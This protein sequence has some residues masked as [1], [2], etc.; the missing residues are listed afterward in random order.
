MLLALPAGA[1][2]ADEI[3][4]NLR[5]PDGGSIVVEIVERDHPTYRLKIDGREIVAIMDG[6]GPSFR[7]SLSDSRGNS[8]GRISSDEETVSMT[9][10]RGNTVVG[11][12]G[13][14]D[15]ES[16][17]ELFDTIPLLF[18]DAD[19]LAIIRG[20]TFLPMPNLTWGQPTVL[21]LCCDEGSVS[22]CFPPSADGT[23]GSGQ[24]LV[25]CTHGNCEINGTWNCC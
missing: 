15:R 14:L 25:A 19:N 2:T 24:E 11:P 21:D 3:I 5:T 13:G 18:A 8:L 23:C 17:I 10:G 4:A 1:Q 6:D 12:A 16:A 22:N 20:Q 9:D 7:I